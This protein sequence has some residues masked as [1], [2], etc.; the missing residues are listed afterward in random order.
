[1]PLFKLHSD[2]LL[3]LT[4]VLLV[5]IAISSVSNIYSDTRN[6]GPLS[7]IISIT[8]N[9][10]LFISLLIFILFFLFKASDLSR[11]F[12]VAFSAS[13]YLL[14]LLKVF[15]LQKYFE[16]KKVRQVLILGNN[17][18]GMNFYREMVM[19]SGYGFSLK[20]YLTEKRSD[21][22]VP[23]NL[24]TIAE[25]ENV[26]ETCDVKD[27]VIA[28]SENSPYS[29][30]DIIDKCGN[31][32]VRVHIIPDLSYIT[33]AFN[34]S[35]VRSFPIISLRPTPLDL[36]TNR[37]VKR[38]MDVTVT[39]FLFVTIF[40]W[41]WPLLSILVKFSS[42]GPVFFKQERWGLFNKTITCYKF[43][44]MYVNSSDFS[45]DGKFR[46]ASKSDP[47]IT[48]I[49]AFLRRTNLD[50]LPQFWNVLVG[51]MSLIGPRP[52]AIPH[53]IQ[54]RAEIQ[55]YMQRHK[56]KPGITGWAQMNGYRGEAKDINLMKRRVEC[57]TWYI[58]NWTPM[59][60]TRIFL[61]T[62]W[63]LFRGDKNAY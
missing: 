6:R 23:E 37:I 30:K 31:Y 40:W 13:F 26:L 20:G 60:D 38:F 49:G 55:N 53:N 39:L 8:I 27:V 15:T 29:H 56:A 12:V 7:E 62:V 47:R 1:M 52:H 2:D 28:L 41:L 3:L 10:L 9:S 34:I 14:M 5:W 24:G 36:I 63:M 33:Q 43:R 25:L 35:N 58:E 21:N 44:S 4:W 17:V 48:K 45:E 22:H 18:N 11:R 16:N 19:N 54:L 57:D 46:Q 51:N 32:S 42:K 50:E 59:L 61:K